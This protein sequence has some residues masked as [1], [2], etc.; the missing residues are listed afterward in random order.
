MAYSED[1]DLQTYRNLVEQPTEF[2]DGFD[3]K[4]VVGALFL[5]LL[6]VPGSIYI[7]LVAGEAVGP[8]ARWVT[9]FLFAEVAK[10]SLKDLRQQEVF[11][12]Y[13]MAGFIMF[14]QEGL[15]WNIFMAKSEAFAA[16][17]ISEDLPHWVVPQ[18]VVQGAAERTLFTWEW[19][20]ALGVF[21][22]TMVITRVDQFG[23]GYFLYRVT[24]DVERLPFPMAS[25]GASGVL[26]MVETK[27]KSLQWRPACFS[28]G[29]VL[30][31]V[32]GVI[33]LGIPAITGILFRKPL[34]LIPIPWI[35]L[36]PPMQDILP[37]TAVNIVPNLARVLMGMVLP[38]WAVVGGFV[39]LVVTFI[40]NP[41]LYNGGI[42]G[43]G[44]WFAE[45][46]GWSYGGGV[47]HS[48]KPGMQTV[49][50]LFH[51]NIDFY[52]SFG[53]G[54]TFFIAFLGIFQAVWGVIKASIQRRRED[55][56][57]VEGAEER[58]SGWERLK[59]GDPARGDISIWLAVG[60]YVCSTIGYIGLSSY[61]IDGFPW[62]LFLIYGF[63]YTP[64]VAYAAAKVE[65]LVGQ[66]MVIP[67]VREATYILS[68]YKGVGIWFAPVPMHNYGQTVK[69]F[70]II[71]LTGTRVMS[72]MKTIAVTIPIIT[73]CLIVFC[74][75]IWHGAP[76]NSDHYPYAQKA[77]DLM[78]KNRALMISSTMEG[79]R[80]LFFEAL[81][82]NYLGVGF[83][84]G[85]VT[86]TILSVF[87]LPTL[88]VFGV[89]RGLNQTNPAG[90][91]PEF[92][93]ALAGRYYFQRKFGPMWLKYTPAIF[94]GFSCGL[95]LVGLI[96]VALRLIAKSIAPLEY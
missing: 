53:L 7:R 1:R 35:E 66:V 16:M 86:Y 73:I 11:V 75:V 57:A 76:L 20:P 62:Y 87:G 61:L 13:Y 70:R 5:G 50:T 40:L 6:I 83:L 45:L 28:I 81:N 41:I 31:L 14:R 44:S 51:N 90:L 19:L 74:S 63:V 18:S 72:I 84:T 37:A 68:G 65:G 17:G 49:D 92:L 26:A 21:A 43:P 58:L 67:L 88:L 85:A 34:F 46:T 78:A 22:A 25:I 29:G 60:L 39:G 36:T 94:A 82:G 27:E 69:D 71:E 4:T 2:E 23:L 93:G 12:L 9:I 64:L 38:F 10:R 91:F 32:F 30:G 24:S 15:L 54:I 55:R 8:A 79:R 59:R 95:G 42:I 96:S 77:W 89:V 80:S 56:A 52:L 47:L 3:W 48:W 33:Y